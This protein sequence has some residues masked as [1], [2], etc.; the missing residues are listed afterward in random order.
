MSLSSSPLARKALVVLSVAGVLAGYVGVAP[1]RAA[2]APFATAAFSGSAVGSAIHADALAS[3]T[4]RVA[5][6]DVA[7]G[8]AAVNS[9][10]LTA[11]ATNENGRVVSPALGA[12]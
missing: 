2:A 3:G 8:S 6:A 12:A 11:Q 4:T 5:N 9:K 1:A 10:G 7:L